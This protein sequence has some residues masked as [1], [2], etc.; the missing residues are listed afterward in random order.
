MT[1]EEFEAG[2]K[3]L[4]AEIPSPDR[5]R[6]FAELRK[7]F[8]QGVPKEERQMASNWM[9]AIVNIYSGGNTNG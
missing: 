6:R 7:E 2:A 3:R 1:K 9:K 4:G 5:D 8:R